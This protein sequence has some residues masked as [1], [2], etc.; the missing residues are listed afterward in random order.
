MIKANQEEGIN[1]GKRREVFADQSNVDEVVLGCLNFFQKKIEN[2][3][4]SQNDILAL[5][6]LIQAIYMQW[7][8]NG[9]VMDS[10]VHPKYWSLR[11]GRRLS[12]S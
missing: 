9:A 5:E 10:R 7:R 11:R 6:H 4:M 2:N 1:A 12:K 8:R 3:L